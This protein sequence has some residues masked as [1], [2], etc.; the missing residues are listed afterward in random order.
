MGQVELVFRSDLS[1]PV[2]EVWAWITSVEGISRELWP[3]LKMTV[4]RHVRKLGDVPL[5][6]GKPLFRSWVLLFGVVPIDRSD[7]TLLELT[8]LR[9]FVEES[10][11]L[12]MSLWRHERSLEPQGARTILVDRLTFRPR[13]GTVLTR[14]FIRRVFTH[15]HDVLRRQFG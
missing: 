12:S 2:G 7:L 14:W 6:P 11:L 3:I 1:A 10:P 13:F 5:T 8:D 15:R 9:G 4:P